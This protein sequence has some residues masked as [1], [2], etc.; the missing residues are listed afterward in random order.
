M[1]VVIDRIAI[2]VK[3]QIAGGWI[4]GNAT[5]LASEWFVDTVWF[6][7]FES[8]VKPNTRFSATLKPEVVFVLSISGAKG[9]EKQRREQN[10]HNQRFIGKRIVF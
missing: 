5:T 10:F 3:Q 7:L 9:A 1:S 8:M 4:G 2:C 6:E